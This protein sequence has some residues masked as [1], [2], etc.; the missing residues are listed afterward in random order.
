M[1]SSMYAGHDNNVEEVVVV[2]DLRSDALTQLSPLMKQA[3]QEAELSMT[4]VYGEDVTTHGEQQQQQQKER[5]IGRIFR[6]I[7]GP[8][9]LFGADSW[10]HTIIQTYIVKM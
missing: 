7:I 3:M 2:V 6:D 8:S 4:P 1:S 9:G 5:L 10:V